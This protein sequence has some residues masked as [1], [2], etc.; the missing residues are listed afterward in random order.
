MLRSN[1]Q[2]RTPDSADHSVDCVVHAGGPLLPRGVSGGRDLVFHAQLLPSDQ[3]TTTIASWR[4]Q[5]GEI[6][7]DG[8]V[9][10][11]VGTSMQVLH[12][13]TTTGLRLETTTLSSESSARA[14]I[15][16]AGLAQQQPL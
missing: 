7:A 15:T 3:L 2:C 13:N 8:R 10:A 14:F 12:A 5:G 1:A 11:A 6:L 9:F 16:L 4:G